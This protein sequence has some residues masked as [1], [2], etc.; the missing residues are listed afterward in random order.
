MSSSAAAPPAAVS[1]QIE[2]QATFGTLPGTIVLV[3]DITCPTGQLANMFVAVSQ[4]QPVGPNRNGFGSQFGILCT[5]TKQ[6]F[7]LTV[8]PGPF[9]AGDAF[10]SVEAVAGDFV[11]FD[12]R[13]IT[14]G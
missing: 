8:G 13:V 9:T 6:V 5:G 3:I 11:V 2:R 12:S 7:G 4:Q 1:V 14:I 10:A